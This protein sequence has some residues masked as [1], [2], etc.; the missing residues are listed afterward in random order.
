MHHGRVASIARRRVVRIRRKYASPACRLLDRIKP[1]FA[2]I[3]IGSPITIGS[4]TCTYAA[5][6][7]VRS[8]EIGAVEQKV[9]PR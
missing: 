3:D 8:L 4:A 2:Q 5:R 1:N 7:P 6:Q 9:I